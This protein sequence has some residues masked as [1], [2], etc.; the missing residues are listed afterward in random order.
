MELV[1]DV[2]EEDLKRHLF[3]KRKEKLM[4]AQAGDSLTSQK[5]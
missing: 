2:G 1:E 5:D 3:R 4:E